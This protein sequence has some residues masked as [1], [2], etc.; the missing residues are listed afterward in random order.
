[1]KMVVGVVAEMM[2]TQNQLMG[3]LGMRLEKAENRAASMYELLE[4]SA[5]DRTMRELEVRKQIRREGREDMAIQVATK[6]L[7]PK[8]IGEHGTTDTQL[9]MLVGSMTEDQI[10]ALGA[11]L[12]PDQI[13]V[14]VGMMRK[15]AAK[16]QAAEDK[17]KHLKHESEE[18]LKR[19]EG[20]TVGTVL[21]PEEGVS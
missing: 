21:T 1:M 10:E 9:E 6:V 5:N 13:P 11:Q 12:R 2:N 4:K 8:L 3:S 15:L 14:F 19:A 17:E 18:I 20:V 7:L 16:K